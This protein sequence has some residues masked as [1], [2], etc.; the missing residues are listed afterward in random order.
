MQLCFFQTLKVK[1]I[2]RGDA[3]TS[4]VTTGILKREVSMNTVFHCYTVV[5]LYLTGLCYCF[6]YM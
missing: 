4:L 5:C 2:L 6:S 1:T 3:P